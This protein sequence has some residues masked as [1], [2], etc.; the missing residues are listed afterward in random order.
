MNLSF[1]A[2]IH[3]D[4]SA[5]YVRPMTPGPLQ[6][7]SEV[8]VRLR[9]AS[10]APIERLLLRSC[11]D[12]E[13]F[14][15]EMFPS[16]D[17]PACRWWQA[18]LRLSMP[19]TAYR[20]LLFTRDGAWWYTGGGLQRHLPTDAEDFRI[21]A[22]YQAP[23]WVRSSVFY[24]VF[25]D[26]FADG[27]PSN[28]V[29][30]NE[31]QYRGV[32]ARSRRWG[33]APAHGREA[34]VEFFG[35]DLP[36]VE[37][38]LAYLDDLGVN[39]LYFTPLFSAYSNHRYDCVD[40]ENVD[41]HLGGN[42]SLASLRRALTGRGMRYLLDIVPNH[43]GVMHPWF[44]AAQQDPHAPTAEYFTFTKHP[45]QYAT[46]L[47]VASLPKLNYRSAALRRAMY[48]GPDAVFRRW[49][50]PPYAADG[51][52]IDVANM[53]ARQGAEQLGLEV[54]REIRRAVKE[55]NPQAYLLGENFFDASW[56]L[57]GDTWDASMNY[58][59]FMQPLL[60]WLTRFSIHQHAEPRDV[61]SFNRWPTEALA[62]AWQSFRAA[63]PW[64]VAAQQ[65]NLL[66]SHDTPRIA[67]LVE[68]PALHRL[69]VA[70]LC[71]YVGAP[72]IYYGNEIGLGG[73]DD[74]E[75]RGCMDWEP[76]HWDEDLR[77]FYQ[78][79]IHL[80]RASPAL[81]DGGFQVLYSDENVLAFQRDTDDECL[82]VVGNRG[83]ALQA[84]LHLP[85]AHGGVANGRSFRE[86]FTGQ[87]LRVEGGFLA[88]PPLAP[89]A[90]VWRAG[91]L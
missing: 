88:L 54:G 61:A 63:I 16:A 38:K 21:L 85:V 15:T 6:I 23:D 84:P 90:Q 9:A 35:G 55:T 49:L 7:G 32:S 42:Q 31:Y 59:G 27:D 52:R 73:G 47:G 1:H 51:W 33:D 25:P 14:F 53:L 79:L 19:L 91:V 11:P 17:E 57:Q 58:A 87:L 41:S 36:G 13:Q 29:R 77:A 67:T 12:G 5:R 46:W 83:P 39:A 34:M 65:F 89:G 66:G 22:G 62:R 81:I 37:Q 72:C 50:R 86:V 70:F 40:Y 43:C 56:Q 30:D 20:F 82:I 71:T 75:A 74:L 10:D 28:N 44:Q 2:S 80:R 68:N 26:R 4:G 76:A 45:E 78:K 64:Q 60:Y 24:Q 69:A 8:Q 3:H 18:T 48:A